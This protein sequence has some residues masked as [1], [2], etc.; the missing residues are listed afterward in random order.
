MCG[1][2]LTPNV[3]GILAS[4]QLQDHCHSNADTASLSCCQELLQTP[5]PFSPSAP[6]QPWHHLH[7]GRQDADPQDPKLPLTS[8]GPNLLQCLHPAPA[9]VTSPSSPT[10][11]F[12]GGNKRRR[13]NVSPLATAAGTVPAS[14]ASAAPESLPY[15]DH[16]ASSSCPWPVYIKRN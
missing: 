7:G 9:I 8:K 2:N 13:H 14:A 16:F 12:L 15:K 11:F 5:F 6:I 3:A 4:L 1:K 10:L